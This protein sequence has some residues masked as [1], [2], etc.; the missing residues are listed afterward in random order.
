M[1]Y[2]E[3]E[4]REVSLHELERYGYDP[5]NIPALKQLGI[6]ILTI[7][8]PPHYDLNYYTAN[9]L[10]P[11]KLDDQYYQDYEIVP[12]PLD[13]VKAIKLEPLEG[14][15]RNVENKGYIESSMGF[16]FDATRLSIQDLDGV[17]KQMEAFN[18]EGDSVLKDYDG[19]IQ[20]LSLDKVKLLYLECTQRGNAI[21]AV[22][23]YYEEQIASA[24]SIEELQAI[25]LTAGWPGVD[26]MPR[27]KATA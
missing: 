3:L 15:S 19:Q 24:K 7:N 4:K 23:W 6:Y 16:R 1:Y 11:Y 10:P 5:Y 17:I 21:Y 8:Q 26:A 14:I 2:S 22:K 20:L 12:L 18:P 25:D 27:P 9:L 13:M